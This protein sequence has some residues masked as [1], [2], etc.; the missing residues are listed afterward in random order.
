METGEKKSCD[1]MT[2]EEYLAR[3][4]HK[5]AAGIPVKNGSHPQ[6]TI[7]DIQFFLSLFSSSS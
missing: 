7:S 2:L 3:H 5:N 1:D 4:R 6:R